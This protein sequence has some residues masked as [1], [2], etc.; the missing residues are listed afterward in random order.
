MGASIQISW[1]E[2]SRNP[3]SIFLDTIM[4]GGKQQKYHFNFP[5]YKNGGR[6]TAWILSQFS[7]IQKCQEENSNSRE[8]MSGYRRYGMS[9]HMSI[10]SYDSPFIFWKKFTFPPIVRELSVAFL[11]QCLWCVCFVLE[12]SWYVVLLQKKC[13]SECPFGDFLI[14][15]FASYIGLAAL[16]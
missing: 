6:K 3:L 14:Q 5:R 11:L 8:K 9:H 13:L 2:N 1:E 10:A 15:F 7:Y 16:L 4:E 12:L